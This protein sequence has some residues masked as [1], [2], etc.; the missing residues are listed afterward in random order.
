[1]ANMGV[2]AIGQI[3][4]DGSA[5]AIADSIREELDKRPYFSLYKDT[6][7]VGG[8]VLGGKPTEFNSD[9]KF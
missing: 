6:Y 5:G 2:P 4:T 3:V 1:M 7:F 9:V 8:T